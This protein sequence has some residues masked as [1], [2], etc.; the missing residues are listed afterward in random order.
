MHPGLAAGTVI[1]TLITAHP[2]AQ[3]ITEK[4]LIRKAHEPSLPLLRSL[5]DLDR[6]HQVGEGGIIVG[7]RTTGVVGALQRSSTRSE[8]M[9]LRPS[10]T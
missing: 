9:A 5:T 3:Q 8:P 10:S 7:A 6:H 2:T 1:Q 4:E